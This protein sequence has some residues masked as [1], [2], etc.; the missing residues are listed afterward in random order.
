MKSGEDFIDIQDATDITYAPTQEGEYRVQVTNNRNNY[1][2]TNVSNIITAVHAP[3]VP[4]VSGYKLAETI[5]SNNIAFG[6]QG[7][8]LKVVVD[9]IGNQ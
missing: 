7:D 1:N 4:N 6:A 5:V 9:N 2:K 3:I 8:E